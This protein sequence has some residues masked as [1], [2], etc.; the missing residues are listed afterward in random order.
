MSRSSVKQAGVDDSALTSDPLQLLR[1]GW[2]LFWKA[3]AEPAWRLGCDLRLLHLKREFGVEILWL[4]ILYVR[5]EMRFAHG[6][7]NCQEHR[8]RKPVRISNARQLSRLVHTYLH[9]KLCSFLPAPWRENRL[10]DGRR[11]FPYFGI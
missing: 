6:T 7:V 1:P 8:A 5:L 9:G 3:L 11:E 2:W 4:A 10:H